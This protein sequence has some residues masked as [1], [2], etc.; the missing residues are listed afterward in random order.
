VDTSA[1]F[2]PVTAFLGLPSLVTVRGKA[3]MRVSNG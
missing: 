1:D 2:R 3:I